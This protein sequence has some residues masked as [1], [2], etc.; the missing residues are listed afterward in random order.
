MNIN[1]IAINYVIAGIL[2][3]ALCRPLIKRKIKMNSFYGI[4]ISEAFKSEERW[5][6]I[7]EY[8][9]RLLFW[10]GIM[11]IITGSIGISLPRH[12]WIVYAWVSAALLAAGLMVVIFAISRYAQKTKRP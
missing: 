11:I 12:E 2:T 9:G 10:W 4:R 6:D 8:G 1:L 3:A 7:N 5:Y